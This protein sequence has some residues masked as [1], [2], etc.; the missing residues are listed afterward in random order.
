MR[1]RHLKSPTRLFTGAVCGLLL[2]VLSIP[3]CAQSGAEFPNVQST[4]ARYDAAHEITLTGTIQE[5]LNKRVAGGP[6]GM[7][8]LI[9]GQEG[10]V[11]AHLGPFLSQE[12]K[13][14]L[15]AGTPVQ[16]VGAIVE[17]HDKQYL[18]AREV[19]VGGRTIEIR[20]T[21]GFLLLAHG[22]GVGKSS[23]SART[24]ENGGMQ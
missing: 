5:V 2:T 21:R 10:L 24:E 13:E 3:I 18:L 16:V 4:G 1:L 17:M 20:N 11:D 23:T 7:H 6:V 8:V 9:A 12:S 15:H 19:T 22:N 14:A